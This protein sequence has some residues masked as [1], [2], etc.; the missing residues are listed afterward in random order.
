VNP[1]PGHISSGTYFV[2]GEIEHKCD[3][4]TWD[5]TLTGYMMVNV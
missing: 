3:G 5:T 2:V 1:L 4:E